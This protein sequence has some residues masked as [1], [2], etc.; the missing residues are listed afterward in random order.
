[1]QLPEEQ[2]SLSESEKKEEDPLIRW[3]SIDRKIAG[4]QV[5][6]VLVFMACVQ[7]FGFTV[8]SIGLVDRMH[9]FG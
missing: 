3:V 9:G 6:A 8:F 4:G 1:M 7:G 2:R 5:L